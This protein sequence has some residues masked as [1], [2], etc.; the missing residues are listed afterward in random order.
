[1][2]VLSQVRAIYPG[3]FDPMTN[4]HLD[5]IARSSKMF[6]HLVVAILKNDEKQPL[7]SVEER[8]EMLDRGRSQVRQCERGYV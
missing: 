6:D 3:T 1:M 8:V 4:G 5:L 2:N 7:F